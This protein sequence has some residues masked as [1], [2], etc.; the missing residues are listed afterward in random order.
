[1]YAPS[2]VPNPDPVPDPCGG[3]IGSGSAISIADPD[4]C[5]PG[6]DPES[7]RVKFMHVRIRIRS[8]VYDL[9]RIRIPSCG[10]ITTHSFQATACLF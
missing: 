4:P 6:M 1:M 7:T 10:S 2:V 8:H 9:I 5:V 3:R